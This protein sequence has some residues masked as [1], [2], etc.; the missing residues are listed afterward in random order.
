[1]DQRTGTQHIS[2]NGDW[3]LGYRDTGIAAPEDLDQQKWIRCVADAW[4]RA[5]DGLQSPLARSRHARQRNGDRRRLERRDSPG[6]HA[7]GPIGVANPRSAA[8][9]SVARACF[10]GPRRLRAS[11]E[12]SHETDRLASGYQVKIDEQFKT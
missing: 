3:E 5:H 1:V 6:A 11:P 12:I 10:A 9:R 7:F 4:G 2:L 8:E